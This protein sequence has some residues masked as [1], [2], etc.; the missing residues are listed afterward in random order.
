MKLEQH[1]QVGAHNPEF[2]DPGPLLPRDGGKEPPKK[3][4]H[5]DGDERSPVAGGPD[6]MNIETVTNGRLREDVRSSI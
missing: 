4:G 1:V 6:E 2:H 3:P 5:I